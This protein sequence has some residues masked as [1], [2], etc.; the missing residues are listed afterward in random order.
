VPQAT[1][2]IATRNRVERLVATLERLAQLPEVPEIVVADNASTDRTV[3]RVRR[4]FPRIRLIELPRNVGAYARTIA[5]NEVRTR[6]VAFCDDDAW[7]TP[8]SIGEGSETLD[9][10][11]SIALLNARHR[12]IVGNRRRRAARRKR[13]F[14]GLGTRRPDQLA[15]R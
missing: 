6:Y 3:Q 11:S 8:G 9:R 2:V 5:V 14:H 10:Y 1:V 15:N 7:W 12:R 13:S 4:Q